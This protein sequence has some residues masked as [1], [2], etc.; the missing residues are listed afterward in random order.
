[1]RIKRNELTIDNYTPIGGKLLIKPFKEMKRTVETIE[2]KEVEQE[3]DNDPTKDDLPVR[4]PVKVKS[5]APYEVQLAEVV[6]VGKG[7]TDYKVGDTVVYSVKFVKDF[8]LFKDTYLVNLH[9][10]YGIYNM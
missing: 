10:L 1:M 8:D 3:E 4:E 2:W 7:V 5:K 9:D 6:A